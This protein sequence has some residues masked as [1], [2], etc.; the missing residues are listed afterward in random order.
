M[1]DDERVTFPC[2]AVGTPYLN[3]P[4][5]KSRRE[6]RGERG[7][8][9]ERKERK[10]RGRRGKKERRGGVERGERKGRGQDKKMLTQTLLWIQVS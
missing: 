10:K 6:L 5:P 3:K 9:G 8:R 7:R 2:A 4:V 1:V